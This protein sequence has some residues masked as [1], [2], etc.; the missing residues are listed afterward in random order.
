[1][2]SIHFLTQVKQTMTWVMPTTTRVMN[3]LTVVMKFTTSFI[4]VIP[5]LWR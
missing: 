1:M 4:V 3:C 2:R 5:D